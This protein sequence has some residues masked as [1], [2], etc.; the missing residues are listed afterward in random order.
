MLV[1]CLSVHRGVEQLERTYT[2][3]REALHDKYH[4]QEARRWRA[5][6]LHRLMHQVQ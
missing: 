1:K 2:M 5:K 3:V 6:A 4:L